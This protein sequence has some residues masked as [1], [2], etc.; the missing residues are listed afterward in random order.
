M[1]TN[2][3]CFGWDRPT[4]TRGGAVGWKGKDGEIRTG[5]GRCSLKREASLRKEAS[6]GGLLVWEAL[7]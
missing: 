2:E 4:R 5:N 1:G 7:A 6:M 3:V